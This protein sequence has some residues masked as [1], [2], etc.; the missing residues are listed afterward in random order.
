MDSEA[1]EKTQLTFFY[2][3]LIEY[4][5]FSVLDS[6]G[7]LQL[8]TDSEPVKIIGVVSFGGVCGSKQPGIYTRV[9]SY[10]DWIG[11]HVWPNGE[12]EPPLVADATN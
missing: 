6:G 1:S 9:A 5:I 11:S 12:I 10:V 2:L 8:L 4:D 3:I 7:P